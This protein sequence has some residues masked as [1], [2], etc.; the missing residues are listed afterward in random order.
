MVA[1]S[2]ANAKWETI[3]SVN[4]GA[5]LNTS[6]DVDFYNFEKETVFRPGVVP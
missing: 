1:C 4:G 6:D 5:T 2:S 3:V